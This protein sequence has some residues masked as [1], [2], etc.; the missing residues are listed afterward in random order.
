MTHTTLLTEKD[1]SFCLDERIQADQIV[2]ECHVTDCLEE[3]IDRW[4]LHYL[5]NFQLRL[6][7]V[8][9]KK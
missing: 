7:M 1:K 9:P 5:K 8:E 4:N 2:L 6:I 3:E